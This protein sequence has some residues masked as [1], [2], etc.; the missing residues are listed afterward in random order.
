MAQRALSEAGRRPASGSR[1]RSRGALVRFVFEDKKISHKS[2]GIWYNMKNVKNFVALAL[3]LCLCLSVFAAC[4]KE[5]EKIELTVFAA[6]SLTETLTELGDRYM[7]AHENVSIV[8][9]FD[10][11]GTLKTQRR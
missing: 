6:A 11:S 5:E 9:N 7:A 3:A 2:G 8:F 1:S 10:S 4:G